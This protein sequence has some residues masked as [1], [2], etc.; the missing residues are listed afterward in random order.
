MSEMQRAR[1][2]MARSAT[3]DSAAPEEPEAF[4]VG[5]RLFDLE[6]GPCNSGLIITGTVEDRVHN[7]NV[8]MCKASPIR[9]SDS[10]VGHQACQ[11]QL[12]KKSWSTCRCDWWTTR[13][14]RPQIAWRWTC[15]SRPAAS[16]VPPLLTTLR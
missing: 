9:T 1:A 14:L 12:H 8:R 16:S 2:L 11:A 15:T 6:P 5:T 13:R 7:L 4:A 10:N 3:A